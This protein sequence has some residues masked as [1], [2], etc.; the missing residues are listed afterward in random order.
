MP[1]FRFCAML[2]ACFCLCACQKAEQR[3]AKVVCVLF[4]F[5]ESTNFPK[6]RQR[7]GKD[8]RVI[9]TRIAPGDVIAAC[10]ITE[11]S[12]AEQELILRCEFPVFTPS[13][14]NLL[15]KRGELRQFEAKIKTIR[16]SLGA[17]VDSALMASQRK[18]LRTDVM[19][20]LHVAERIF[21]AFA[22]P[23]KVL[24]LISDMIEESESYNFVTEKL[25]PERTRAIIAAERQNRRLA[26]LTGVKVYVIGANAATREKFFA[27]RDFWLDYFRAC[28]ANIPHENYG[29]AL[30]NFE[31]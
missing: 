28:G 27:V 20:A 11:K 15:I 8:F 14:D 24:V 3:P 9:Q 29:A 21:K 12:I 19:S 16:D 18:V 7:Y 23:R 5:S 31:E 17:V 10:P 26:D 2:F 6:I 22:Q 30:V 1:N 13:S 4:D 25:N